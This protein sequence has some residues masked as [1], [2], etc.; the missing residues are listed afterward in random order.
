[1]WGE[2]ARD[3]RLFP[4]AEAAE[5]TERRNV[6]SFSKELSVGSAF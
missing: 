1:M 5:D 2:R 3:I 6:L 4:L